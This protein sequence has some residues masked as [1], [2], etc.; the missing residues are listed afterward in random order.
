MTKE[1]TVQQVATLHAL[2][3]DVCDLNLH[4]TTITCFAEARYELVCAHCDY[5][6][7]LCQP[8]AAATV[9]MAARADSGDV[10]PVWTCHRCHRRSCTFSD[11]F[12]L[13]LT[14]GHHG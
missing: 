14:G 13:H 5:K 11:V 8:H 12:N 9:Q 10:M 7:P 4:G 6:R 1:L 3:Y 2:D